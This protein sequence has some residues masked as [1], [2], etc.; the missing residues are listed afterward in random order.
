MKPPKKQVKKVVRLNRYEK[1]LLF[2]AYRVS[3]V[4]GGNPEREVLD[5]LGLEPFIPHTKKK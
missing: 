5:I 4:D 2:L 1:A 3:C